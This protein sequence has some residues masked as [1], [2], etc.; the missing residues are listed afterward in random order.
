MTAEFWSKCEYCVVDVN[1]RVGDEVVEDM[2]D[3]CVV[4]GKNKNGERIIGIVT[5]AA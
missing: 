4:L 3:S 5:L 1:C 2:V